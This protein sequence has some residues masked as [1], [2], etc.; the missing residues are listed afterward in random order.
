MAV[1]ITT[2]PT[3][4]AGRPRARFDW[5]HGP[6]GPVTYYAVGPDGQRFLVMMVE[7]P[8]PEPRGYLRLIVNWVEECDAARAGR[9][10]RPRPV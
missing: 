8:D 2:E 1:A 5:R 4:E 3:V 6:G 10:A 9:L 7:E